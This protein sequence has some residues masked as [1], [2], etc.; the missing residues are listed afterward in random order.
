MQDFI[1]FLLSKAV[2]AASAQLSFTTETC[3]NTDTYLSE[4]ANQKN[5]V[6]TTS[7]PYPE[8]RSHL[9]AT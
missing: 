5:P 2:F 4:K 9:S 3:K 8:T 7:R 6:A 1:S